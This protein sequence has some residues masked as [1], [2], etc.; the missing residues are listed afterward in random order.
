MLLCL[1]TLITPVFCGREA[2]KTLTLRSV[3]ACFIYCHSQTVRFGNPGN[4]ILDPR[5]SFEDDDQPVILNLLNRHP[6]L[7]SG[8][9]NAFLGY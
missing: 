9:I 2:N 8:S 3:L 5:T 4:I 1:E 6:E 7:D